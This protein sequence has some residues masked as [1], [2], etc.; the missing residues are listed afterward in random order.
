[1]ES[2]VLGLVDHAHSAATEFLDDAV[3]RDCLAD[4][5]VGGWHVEHILGRDRYQVN[6]GRSIAHHLWHSMRGQKSENPG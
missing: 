2:S 6:E 3:V 5:R 1:M 4:P